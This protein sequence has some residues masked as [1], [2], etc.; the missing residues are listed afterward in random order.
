MAKRLEKAL[1]QLMREHDIVSA[2]KDKANIYHNHILAPLVVQIFDRYGYAGTTYF[3]TSTRVNVKTANQIGYK[4][5][6]AMRLSEGYLLTPDKPLPRWVIRKRVDDLI[7]D[8]LEDVENLY[9]YMIL[10]FGLDGVKALQSE[11]GIKCNTKKMI[12]KSADYRQ[13][14]KVETREF[15][16]MVCGGDFDGGEQLTGRRNTTTK[17]MNTSARKQRS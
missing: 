16:E 11:I 4:R 5:Q 8:F 14:L 13:I 2:A 3:A 12:E 1:L 10:H 7:R 17:T 15:A 6:A 9:W